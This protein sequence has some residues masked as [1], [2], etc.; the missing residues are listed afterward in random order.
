MRKFKLFIGYLGNGATVCNSAVIENGDYKTIA[1]ISEAGN[2]KLRIKPN[3]IP[4]DAMKSIER[5]AEQ[6]RQKT[7]KYLDLML[8]DNHGYYRILDQICDYTPY[9]VWNTLLN[10]IK[11]QD[12]QTKIELIKNCYFENF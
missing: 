6:H 7:N 9:T 2:I 1:H 8:N 3:Y 10:D 11:D 12:K 4:A 5:T